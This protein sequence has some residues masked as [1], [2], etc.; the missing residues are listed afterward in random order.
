MYQPYPT[1]AQM[2]E[3]ERPPVPPQVANAVKVMYLGAATSILGII[4]DILTVNATKTAI[5]RRSHKLT[6]S[7]IDA[8][9]HALVAGFIVGG[10]I[11]AAAWILVA[12]NCQGGKNWARITG[13]V[14]FAIATIDTI[15]GV[16]A[17]LAFAVKI[18]GVA[19]W[20]IGL[21]AVVFLWQRP[22]TEFFTAPRPS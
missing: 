21:T 16:T 7:Q 8:S 14:L 4:V 22:S 2:P 1:G 10:L 11:G 3:I 9:Q 18:W 19:V 13:T 17:P 12:R 15:V 5:E 20:L 6:M